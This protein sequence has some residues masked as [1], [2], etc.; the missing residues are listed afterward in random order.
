MQG[1]SPSA[2]QVR[3]CELAASFQHNGTTKK[4][5][6]NEREMK[7]ERQTGRDIGE[8]EVCRKRV[9]RLW[10]VLARARL[11]RPPARPQAQGQRKSTLQNLVFP[12]SRFKSGCLK[13]HFSKRGISK[14]LVLQMWIFQ[15][16][17]R[18][19][20]PPRC[21]LWLLGRTQGLN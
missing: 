19:F 4:Q 9:V 10:P 5:E 21:G 2:T 3:G 11:G 1:T 12:K 18:A 6:T 7:T 20:T 13:I 15:N 8:T 17:P 14:H 16:P